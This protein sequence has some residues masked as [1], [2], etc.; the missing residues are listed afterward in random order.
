[1]FAEHFA[2]EARADAGPLLDGAGWYFD[3]APELLAKAVIDYEVRF[4]LGVGYAYTQLERDAPHRPRFRFH[5][6]VAHAEAQLGG[7]QGGFWARIDYRVPLGSAPDRDTVGATDAYLDPSVQLGLQVG[8]VL[9]AGGGSHDWNVFA[10]VSI[11][12]RGDA[13]VPATTL[14]I[15]D[16]GFD[17]HQWVVGVQHRFGSG[18]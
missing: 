12:D 7:S 9:S 18:R 10:Y 17:Q 6:A 15:L 14:P 3:V 5:E 11:V 4:E 1:V 8:G 2:F 13:D 16:G